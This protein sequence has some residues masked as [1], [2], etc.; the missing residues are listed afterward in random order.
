MRWTPA[1]LATLRARTAAAA[2]RLADGGAPWTVGVWVFMSLG[3][4]G[5]ACLCWERAL[6]RAGAPA[7]RP[8]H[9]LTRD[10]WAAA[11]DP[12]LGV[13]DGGDPDDP[14]A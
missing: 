4:L 14:L 9:D 6:A 10:L 12:P 2:A 11:N 7:L 3:L 1:R 5:L 13:V 8:L